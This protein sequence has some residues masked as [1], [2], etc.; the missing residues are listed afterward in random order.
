MVRPNIIYY[1][2]YYEYDVCDLL[3]VKT[4]IDNPYIF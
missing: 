3:N 1:K 4:N 2:K